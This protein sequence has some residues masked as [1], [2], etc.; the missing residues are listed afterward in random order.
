MYP[1]LLKISVLN[2]MQ[3]R[4]SN[5]E[6]WPLQKKTGIFLEIL[7]SLLKEVTQLQ[8]HAARAYS[9]GFTVRLTGRHI[10]F[11]SNL[12]VG[13]ILRPCAIVVVQSGYARL[14]SSL[15]VA[16]SPDP[17][18]KLGKGLAKIIQQ[19]SLEQELHE[20]SRLVPRPVETGNEVSSLFFLNSNFRILERIYTCQATI[21]S[22]Q[23]M[24][25]VDP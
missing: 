24:P 5:V 4:C 2:L 10:F 14:L 8:F 12:T 25:V 21:I 23:D 9:R 3:I 1:S 6:I 16:S 11:P 18:Q 13:L 22:S 20:G 17:V 19:P 7:T 15:T